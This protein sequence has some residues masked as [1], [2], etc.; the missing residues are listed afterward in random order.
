M[1]AHLLPEHA[2]RLRLA[3]SDA[4]REIGHNPSI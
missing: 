1:V 2:L 4:L 3:L